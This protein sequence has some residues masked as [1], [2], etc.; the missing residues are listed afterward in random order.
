MFVPIISIAVINNKSWSNH[1]AKLKRRPS[2]LEG[3]ELFQL[4]HGEIRI[5]TVIEIVT[6]H[7]CIVYIAH[8]DFGSGWNKT[9]LP[10][11]GFAQINWNNV[12]IIHSELIQL[13]TISEKMTFDGETVHLPPTQKE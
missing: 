2:Y 13:S 8:T 4:T 11:A 10:D 5:A 6:A 1:K 12:D 9:S 7:S 3:Q